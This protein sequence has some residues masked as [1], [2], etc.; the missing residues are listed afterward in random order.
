[1]EILQGWG[2]GFSSLLSQYNLL[3]CV[4]AAIAGTLLAF[5]PGMT[6][7]TIIALLMPFAFGLAPMTPMTTVI[8]MVA[9]CYGAQYGRSVATLQHTFHTGQTAT[10]ASISR[11]ALAAFVG[12]LGVAILVAALIPVLV[13]AALYFGP[14]EFAAAT[15][16]FLAIAMALSPDSPVRSFA[17]VLAGVALGLLGSGLDTGLKLVSF[18]YL[19]LPDGIGVLPLALGMLLVPEVISRMWTNGLHSKSEHASSPDI[20]I[21]QTGPANNERPDRIALTAAIV[22]AGLS[23]CLLPLLLFGLA[24]NVFG[25]LLVGLLTLQSVVPGPQLGTKQPQVLWGVF[26]AIIVASVVSLILLLLGGKPLAALSRINQRLVGPVVLVLACLAEYF[27]GNGAAD[28]ALITLFGALALLLNSGWGRG[29]VVTAFILGPSLVE[30]IQRSMMIV[31]N[32]ALLI[33]GRPIVA[34]V[35][36]LTAIVIGVIYAWRLKRTVPLLNVER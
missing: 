2:Q 36:V 7:T 16:M 32:D 30:N 19:E 22:N 11:V 21:E 26:A 25:V 33:L 18:G 14:A 12:G 35:L 23:A 10:G 9:L 28:V 29:L 5:L 8:V 6:P 3:V 31:R 15:I 13:Q 4:I 34:S 1:M 17:A 20:H 27:G 24:L